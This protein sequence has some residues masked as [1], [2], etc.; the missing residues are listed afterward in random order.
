[1]NLNFYFSF[2]FCINSL[3][4]ALICSF[5]LGFG[6]AC[7]NTQIYSQIGSF[8]ES[9]SAPAFAIFKFVQSLFSSI[10]FFCTSKVTLNYQVYIMVSTAIVGSVTFFIVEQSARRKSRSADITPSING[11]EGD[12]KD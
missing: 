1:M 12:I 2:R 11:G 6:D 10:F 4:L 8:Y 7:M 3:P 5:L 9:N